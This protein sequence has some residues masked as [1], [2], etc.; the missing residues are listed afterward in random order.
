[1][2]SRKTLLAAAA[3]V[4][5]AT[6][7][8]LVPATAKKT[9]TVG[10]DSGWDVG[11]D[12]DTWK[13]HKKFKVGDTLVFRPN[14]AGQDVVLV[15]EQSFDDCVSPDNAQVLSSGNA[16]AVKLGQSGQF[17][18]ICD[19]EGACASGMKLAINVH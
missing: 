8:L 2:A 14:N 13:S 9:F 16:V 12:Y 4:L 19:A 7:A 1:M 5:V 6:A 3:M 15:D 18:F 10:D 17:F 11:V